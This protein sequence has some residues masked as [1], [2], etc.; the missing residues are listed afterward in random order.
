MTE[1]ELKKLAK[2]EARVYLVEYG[3]K[4]PNRDQKDDGLILEL[5]EAMF[6]EAVIGNPHL[7]AKLPAASSEEVRDFIR[8][9]LKASEFMT[10]LQLRQS[11]PR[12]T[13]H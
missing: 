5:A 10:E 13:I 2:D 8:R 7:L 4:F 11:G 12:G 9:M 3:G 6:M 1:E